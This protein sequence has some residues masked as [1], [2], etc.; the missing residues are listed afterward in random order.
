MEHI[1]MVRLPLLLHKHDWA[2]NR[3]PG[4]TGDVAFPGVDAGLS[5][6]KRWYHKGINWIISTAFV[7]FGIKEDFVYLI[8]AT[9]I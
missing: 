8:A 1:K 9:R 6:T 4:T 2:A 3:Q 7:A 5:Y